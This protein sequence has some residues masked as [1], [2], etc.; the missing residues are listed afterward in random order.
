[1]TI[2]VLHQQDTLLYSRS[3]YVLGSETK[4]TTRHPRKAPLTLAYQQMPTADGQT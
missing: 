2:E 4:S 3:S 1:V